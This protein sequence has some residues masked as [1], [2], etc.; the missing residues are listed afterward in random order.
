MDQEQ[1]KAEF[2]RPDA[3]VGVSPERTVQDR[4]I[5]LLHSRAALLPCES[6]LGVLK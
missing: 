4:I 2:P 3:S 6:L 5:G 1:G